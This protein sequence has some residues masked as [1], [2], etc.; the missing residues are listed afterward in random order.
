VGS[1]QQRPVVSLGDATSFRF[2]SAG[3]LVLGMASLAFIFNLELAAFSS[4][5]SMSFFVRL[6]RFSFDLLVKGI[7]LHHVSI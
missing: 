6:C 3:C 5:S 2:G 1:M 7:S 4:T